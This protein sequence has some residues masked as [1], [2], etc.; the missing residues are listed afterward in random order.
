MAELILLEVEARGQY[1]DSDLVAEVITIGDTEYGLQ[2]AR[3]AIGEVLYLL[4]LFDGKGCYITAIDGD[5]EV[6]GL[7]DIVI[8][9][10]GEFRA[11][12]IALRTRPSPLA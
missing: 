12:S 8:V 2:F 6:S 5:Q 7:L 3:E 1:R 9:E 4:E 11:S 10:Q